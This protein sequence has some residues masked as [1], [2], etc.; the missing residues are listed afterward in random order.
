[1]TTT[2]KRAAKGGEVGA[3][4]EWYE[5]GRFI[6]TVAEQPKR[7]GSVARKA[8]KMEVAPFVWE[9]APEGKT[10]IYRQFAGIWGK[11]VDGKLVVLASEQTFR[12]FGKTAEYAQSLADRWNSGERWM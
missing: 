8:C 2:T 4:G 12:Y 10:S 5:G 6:N 11:C 7:Y 3:N 1:M 9:V